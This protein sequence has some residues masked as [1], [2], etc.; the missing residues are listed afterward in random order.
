MYRLFDLIQQT[1]KTI[2]Y[3][4][5]LLFDTLRD[6]KIISLKLIFNVNTSKE[7]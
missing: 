5:L 7:Q 4:Y 2:C 1:N 6:E 3:C